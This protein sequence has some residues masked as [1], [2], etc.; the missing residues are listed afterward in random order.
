MF[1]SDTLPR[2][3]LFSTKIKV[4]GVNLGEALPV[5]VKVAVELFKLMFDMYLI[6]IYRVDLL[7]MMNS[8]SFSIT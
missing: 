2:F 1:F 8:C 5:N 3:W 6:F 7:S 4:E